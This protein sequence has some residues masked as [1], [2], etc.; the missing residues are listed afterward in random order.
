MQSCDQLSDREWDVL[1]FLTEGMSNREIAASLCIALTTVET[2]ITHI[3]RKLDISRRS[4]AV[5]WC[6]F[7]Q[8]NQ[9][10]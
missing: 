8:G 1:R 10:K 7:Q 9:I 6:M 4:Q 3:Y 2:H 5:R